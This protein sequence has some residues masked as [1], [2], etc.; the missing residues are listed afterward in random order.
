MNTPQAGTR[1]EAGPGVSHVEDDSLWIETGYDAVLYRP[2]PRDKSRPF[3]HALSID[4]ED[5]QQ[6]VFDH[7]LP[8][9]DRFVASTHRILE[10]L[11]T[12]GVRATFFVLAV[13][14]K[15]APDLIRALHAAGH[16]VQTHGYDHTLLT[17]QTPAQ[18]REDLLRARG[19]IEDLIGDE[20]YGYRAPKFSIVASTLWALDVLA[21]CGL[22]YDSSIFPARV[23]GYGIKGWP[24]YEHYLRARSGAELV[25]VPVATLRLLGRTL[26]FGGGGYFR[27]L[28]YG[29]IRLGVRLVQRGG[30]PAVFYCHPYEFDREAFA[31]LDLPIGWRTRLHQGI[32]R[33]GFA[34][35]IRELLDEFAFGPIHDL[36]PV[37]VRQPAHGRPSVE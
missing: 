10:L 13:A 26:P 19:I 5:W 35:K 8:V 21:E 36:L 15:K 4:L 34:E 14:A 27:L 31:E 11:D 25:E 30:L 28:P 20:V 22:R 2:I 24:R 17:D 23:R 32:G 6:S 3:T 7:S 18:L 16:E 12:F 37:E 9:S 1:N 29:I 33:Y